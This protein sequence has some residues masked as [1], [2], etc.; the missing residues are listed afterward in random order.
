MSKDTDKRSE[1]EDPLVNAEAQAAQPAEVEAQAA[2]PAEAKAQAAQPAEAEEAAI[3]NNPMC[4]HCGWRNTRLS[5]TRTTLDALLRVFSLRA[6][7]CRTCGSR[8]R[9]R[10][11]D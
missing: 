2:Q 3:P 7:R 6:F 4:P 8:F 10:Y 9:A 1:T 5:H 11:K